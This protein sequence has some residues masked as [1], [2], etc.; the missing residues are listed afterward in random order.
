MKKAIAILVIVTMLVACGGKAS[1][2]AVSV[3]SV[4][5]DSTKVDSS[6]IK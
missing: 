2:P 4:K 3:D 1:V 5:V 6:S